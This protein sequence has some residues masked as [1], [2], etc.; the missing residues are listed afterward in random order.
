MC[1]WG[2]AFKSAAWPALT[3]PAWVQPCSCTQPSWSQNWLWSRE[4]SP[5]PSL[6]LILPIK[7][8]FAL[9]FGLYNGAT[10]LLFIVLHLVF[11]VFNNLL[12]HQLSTLCSKQSV[13]SGRPAEF[14]IPQDITPMPLHLNWGWRTTFILVTPLLYKRMLGV[15]GG[16]GNLLSSWLDPPGMETLLYEYMKWGGGGQWLE[17]QHSQPSMPGKKVLSFEWGLAGTREPWS[18]WLCLPG[19]LCTWGLL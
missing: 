19:K 2:D 9:L 18:S 4:T 12:R 15:G 14:F 17:P 7:L 3:A 5:W 1:G 11:M 10:S 16:S 6:S 8:L 13:T